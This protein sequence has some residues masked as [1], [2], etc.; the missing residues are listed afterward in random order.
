MKAESARLDGITQDGVAYKKS[1]ESELMTKNTEND[2]L[3]AQL[4]TQAAEVMKFHNEIE[5]LRINLKI[6]SIE[7]R[8]ES[9]HS[10]FDRKSAKR[11][12][13]R[14]DRSNTIIAFQAFYRTY[15]I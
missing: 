12:A 4:Q 8:L 9:R 15:C 14:Y 3:A 1:L 5:G 2:T 6:A 7:D 13:I 11:H 10:E